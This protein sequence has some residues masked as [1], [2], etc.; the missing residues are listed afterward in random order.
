MSLRCLSSQLADYTWPKVQAEQLA[1]SWKRNYA[2]ATN[3]TELRCK[4]DKP[5]SPGGQS[6]LAQRVQEMMPW[7]DARRRSP[8][9]TGPHSSGGMAGNHEGRAPNGE[10]GGLG[11]GTTRALYRPPRGWRIDHVGSWTSRQ[12]W[13]LDKSPS[14]SGTGLPNVSQSCWQHMLDDHLQQVV[15]PRCAWN[16]GRQ[17]QQ[18]DASET[19]KGLHRT[20]ASV[21]TFCLGSAYVT[22]VRRTKH[23]LPPA[24]VG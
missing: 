13:R 19:H 9:S 8:R 6:S 23:A 7:V 21:T 10:G 15:V 14:N 2:A 16:R 12:G 4:G 5:R 18:P 11:V 20:S 22:L 1:S 17:W 24:T 3:V